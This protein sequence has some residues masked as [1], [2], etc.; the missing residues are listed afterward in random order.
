MDT[1]RFKEFEVYKDAKEFRR[2]IKSFLEKF[3]PEER[4]ALKDQINRSC[5]SVLLNIAE[6]S[7]K[8]SDREFA[9][10][11]ETA[12]ASLN[13]VVAGFDMAHDDGIISMEELML[14][15]QKGGSIA[16][17]LGGFMK[18]LLMQS[19]VKGQESIVRSS[20]AR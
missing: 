14:V 1:F 19:T 8:M 5:L 17:Q 18:K 7:A 15:E 6:G 11:L 2:M 13:E 10:F 12:I 3:P 9:R 4:Y 20:A 16:K